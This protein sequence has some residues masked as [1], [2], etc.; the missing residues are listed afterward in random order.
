MKKYTLL[1]DSNRVLVKQFLI[2]DETNGEVK[3]ALFS[4]GDA[5]K[6]Y[7]QSAHTFGEIIA[8][9][10]TAFKFDRYGNERKDEYKVGDTVYFKQYPGPLNRSETDDLGRPQGDYLYTINDIDI[11]G[12]AEI[13]ES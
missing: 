11:L 5:E 10:P 8:M 6:E 2:Q 1:P 7:Y 9:G 12:H 3:I 13:E 4:G